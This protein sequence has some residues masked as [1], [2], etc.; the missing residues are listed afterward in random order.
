MKKLEHKY[1]GFWIRLSAT[2]VDGL[3]LIPL[4]FGIDWI[5]FNY[6]KPVDMSYLEYMFTPVS[7]QAPWGTYETVSLVLFVLTNLLY[8][9]LMTS[10]KQ[11]T[12]GKM[13]F[14]LKV[15]GEN[16]EKVSFGRAVGRYFSYSLSGIFY[17]G[18]IMVAF[19]KTK[20]G[21]HDKVCKTY[22]VY[23]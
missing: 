22:V 8:Y 11:G 10:M 16:S 6:M 18:Y 2:L 7:V 14:G 21:L 20:Q 23:K 5:L 17:I 15:V 19:S 13:V 1:A 12:V 9:A 3:I 4:L